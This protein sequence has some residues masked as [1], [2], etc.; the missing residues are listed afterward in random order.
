MSVLDGADD[1]ADVR[2]SGKFKFAFEPPAKNSCREANV[3]RVA[4]GK[5]TARKYIKKV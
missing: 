3:G 4:D 5:P 1:S 2:S